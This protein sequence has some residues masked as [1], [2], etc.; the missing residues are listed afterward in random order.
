MASFEKAQALL[1]EFKGDKYLHG[2]GVLPQMGGMTAGLGKRAALVRDVFPG[3]DAYVS[4]IKESLAGAGVELIGEIEGAR[5]NAPLEDLARITEE[6][7]ELD[8]DVNVSFGGGSTIDA[9]KAA[10]ALRTLGGQIEDYF[11]TGLVTQALTESGK[12]LTPHVAIQTASSSGAHLTKYS[13]RLQLRRPSD[14]I[15]QH[16]RRPDR[17]EEAHRRRRRRPRATGL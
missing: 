11:G 16:H 17:S 8:P 12:T 4:T 3:A 1:R 7:T 6:L 15:L 5:P 10:E 13:N 14:Q 2:L 9:T